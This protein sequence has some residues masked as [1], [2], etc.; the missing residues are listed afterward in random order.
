MIYIG[1]LIREQLK[2]Q[3][4]TV[5]WFAKQMS[6][7]RTKIYSIFE[8]RSIDTSELL[9]ISQILGYDFFHVYVEELNRRIGKITSCVND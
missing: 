2:E 3:D 5:I 4:K 1:K 9:H 6:C 7:S 8:K